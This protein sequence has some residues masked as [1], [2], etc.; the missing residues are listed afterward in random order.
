MNLSFVNIPGN[1]DLA[2]NGH[3]LYADSYSD[4]VVF[5]ISDAAHAHA[6]K[7]FEQ[8]VYRPQLFL[9]RLRHKPRFIVCSWLPMWQ[10]YIDFL[11]CIQQLAVYLEATTTL[12]RYH[13]QAGRFFLPPTRQLK[14]TMQTAARRKHGKICFCL[15]TISTVSYSSITSFNI[16]DAASPEVKPRPILTT[17]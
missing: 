16:A 14:T 5:D 8:C 3:Y 11:H 13:H 17:G 15:T 9:L 10:R 2:V 6:V 1:Q 12:L 7:F 4:L